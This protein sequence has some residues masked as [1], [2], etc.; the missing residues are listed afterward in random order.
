MS[1]PW[2][3]QVIDKGSSPAETLHKICADD[4]SSKISGPKVIWVNLGGTGIEKVEVISADQMALDYEKSIA[5]AEAQIENLF[6]D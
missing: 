4:P 2:N 3:D 6:K 1:F 5:D